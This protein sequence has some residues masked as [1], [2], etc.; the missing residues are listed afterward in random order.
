LSATEEEKQLIFYGAGHY[1]RL[2]LDHYADMG[3]TPLCFAD[4]NKSIH[5]TK[6]KGEKTDTECEILPLSEA[7]ERY[8]RFELVITVVPDSYTDVHKF[9]VDSGINAERIRTPLPLNRASTPVAVPVSVQPK[10][11]IC[12]ADINHR[13]RASIAL[14]FRV[15]CRIPQEQTPEA[16]YCEECEHISFFPY[17]TDEQLSRYYDGYMD[18]FFLQERIA[19][20]PNIASLKQTWTN[21]TSDHWI[22]RW[23]LWNEAFPERE[24]FTGHI[25]DF[26]SGSSSLLYRI[27]PNAGKVTPYNIGDRLNLPEALSKCDMLCAMQVLEHIAEPAITLIGLTKHLKEGS[28]VWVEVP[29]DYDG[30]LLER[31]TEIESSITTQCSLITMHEHIQHFSSKSLSALL[32]RCRVEPL[33]CFD[34]PGTKMIAVLGRTI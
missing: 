18:Y 30:E 15:R 27:F 14:F 22:K 32:N 34:I 28:M 20:E 29:K 10:C 8:P 25:V 3:I 23:S 6:I 1:G 4:A 7:L 21:Q 5:H 11:P 16:I 17:P 24:T 31:W 19:F 12:G 33:K 13:L 2:Y 26:G 9:L